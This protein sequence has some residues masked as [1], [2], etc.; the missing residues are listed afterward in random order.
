[1][2]VRIRPDFAG[3]ECHN[4]NAH[5]RIRHTLAE[6]KQHLIDAHGFVY[7]ETPMPDSN[8]EEIIDML[9]PVEDL[10]RENRELRAE[11]QRLQGQL[12]DANPGDLEQASDHAANLEL[13]IEQTWRPEVKA[14]REANASLRLSNDNLRS[15]L[16]QSPHG[17]VE[18]LKTLLRE[19]GIE[20]V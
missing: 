17:E 6:I 16:A 9:L 8:D 19:H 2:T 13:A 15:L 12:M 3:P 14:L 20:D 11:N 10:R 4:V 7:D 1:M 5:D 18:R